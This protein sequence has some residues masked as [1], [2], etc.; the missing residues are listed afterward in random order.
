MLLAFLTHW[1]RMAEVYAVILVWIAVP[2]GFFACYLFFQRHYG[3][4]TPPT[5]VP[6]KPEH[7]E[8]IRNASN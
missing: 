1:Y 5:R 4:F 7:V 6:T 8:V 2:L 3:L